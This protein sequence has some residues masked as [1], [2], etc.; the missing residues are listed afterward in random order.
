MQRG[1]IVASVILSNFKYSGYPGYKVK[2]VFCNAQHCCDADIE[3]I[4]KILQYSTLFLNLIKV[5]KI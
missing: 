2:Y 5:Y 4:T 1:V 3:R